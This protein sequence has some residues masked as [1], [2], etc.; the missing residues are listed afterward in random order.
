MSRR[1]KRVGMWGLVT[2]F[3]V[4]MGLL[5]VGLA[6]PSWSNLG[7][8][9]AGVQGWTLDVSWL[10]T[11]DAPAT[12]TRSG[13]GWDVAGAARAR[14]LMAAGSEWRP[15]VQDARM[16]LVS[17]VGPMWY[18]IRVVFVPLWPVAIAMGLG[19]AGLRWWAG[20]NVRPAHCAACGYDVRGLTQCP[21]CGGLVKMLRAIAP[22]LVSGR[23]GRAIARASRGWSGRTS[24][25]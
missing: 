8:L 24:A 18:D 2:G 5:V 21:E 13:Q 7:R 1:V 16:G 22:W 3:V 20:R 12:M 10:K 25:A 15:T 6:R 17:N 14:L 4:V 19:A 9:S 11:A 23:G